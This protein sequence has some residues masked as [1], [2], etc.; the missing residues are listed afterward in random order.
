[1]SQLYQARFIAYMYSLYA[2][3]V[4]GISL[5]NTDDILNFGEHM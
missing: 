3:L 2:L 4:Y 1:M 5:N